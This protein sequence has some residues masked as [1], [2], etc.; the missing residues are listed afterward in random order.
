MDGSIDWFIS[1][2][3][4]NVLDIQVAA[5]TMSTTTTTTPSKSGEQSKSVNVVSVEGGSGDAILA[6]VDKLESKVYTL[7]M[8]REDKNRWERRAPLAPSHI[9]QLVKKGIRC[10]VQ[11]STLRN[12]SN[13]AYQNAGAI[14][15]EDLRDCD[16]I[17]AVKEVP[18]EYLFPGKTYIFFSHTIKAQPYNMPMLDEINK[19]NIRLIDYERIT[20]DKNRRLVRFGAFAGYAGMIDMLHALGDRLLAKGFSTPFL[21][22][23]YSYVYSRLENAMDAVRAIG[24]E[25]SQVGLPD[26]LTPFTFAFTSDGAVAQGALSIFKLLPH[27]MITPDEM[28][29]IV[30]NK[31][32]ERGILYGTIVTSEHMV[33][34]KDPKKKFDKKEYY[35]DPSQYKSIFYEKYAPHIS[36]I[37]NCMYWDAKFPR[38]IT[39]RQM[40]ELV[41]T[42]NSRLVG[43]ADISADING[44]LEFLMKTTS[45]DSPLFVYDPKTQEIHDPTTD[46]KYMYR[47]GILFLAVDNLP[48][49]FPREATQWFGD[50]LLQFMEAV[51]KSDPSKPYDKMDDLPAEIKRAVITAHG[52]LTPPFEYIKE[53]RKKRE[54]MFGKILI[55]GAGYTSHPVIDYLTR[56]PSHVLT[57]ADIDVEQTRKVL[58][59]E[60]DNIDVAIVDVN[61]PVKL[62]ELVKKQTVVI[63]LLPEDLTYEVAKSCLRNKKHLISIGYL[64]DE[65]RSLSAE[66]KANNLTFLMEMGLDPG[67]DHLEAARVI[68]EVQSQGGRIRTFVS[69]AGGLPAPESSDNPL[70][71]K[72]SWSPRGVL[73][74]CTLDAKYRQDGRDISIPGAEVYK[75][76]QKVDIFPALALEGVPN[77]NCLDLAQYY[78]IKDCNTLFRGTLRYKGFCQVI[79]AAVE[80]GLLDETVYSYL[81]PSEASL[82]WNQALRKILPV[83]LNENISTEEIFRRKLRTRRGY[84]NKGYDDEKITSILSVFE[85]LGIFSTT[86]DIAQ[87]GTYIDGF[88]ELLKGKLEFSPSERDLIILHH[89]FGIEWPGGKHETKTSTLVYYGDKDISAMAYC[90]GLPV[91]MAAELLV[92]GSLKERGVVLPITEEYYKPI[93]KSLRNEG[94]QFIHRCQFDQH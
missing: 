9:E 18:S 47:D 24:E 23:G 71:Y 83:P 4:S 72:F 74:A 81:Q 55:I 75:R 35:N 3:I 37:I 77:R 91:A 39:I 44:S 53:L 13:G 56:N 67:I 16:V 82:S 34:P 46:Q 2:N 58:K 27:K 48:T 21:H 61:D 11:P 64:T 10:I 68:N 63:S 85:W 42:G 40:E 89:I 93:L 26:E 65:I 79:E 22:V 92:E 59:F 30:K 76:T 6:A 38:L 32:G 86:I 90:I 78:N 31:K 15:Q 25:I 12:Y 43:V 88:C 1:G 80:V 70:G 50:H 60:P 33:A 20:D 62:D 51:V 57:V 19:K 45:I 49:E 73:E 41:E 17:I 94:I 5:A 29:D 54:A 28:V 14:I 66:A 7:G 8:R 52:S 36:C 84:P 87:K 69:W